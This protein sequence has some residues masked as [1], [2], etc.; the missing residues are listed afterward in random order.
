MLGSYPQTQ[1][2]PGVGGLQGS[3][4]SLISKSD[5]RYE[6][7]LYSINPDENTVALRN[8]KMLGTEGRK[9]GPQIPKGDQLYEFIIFRGSDIK[10]LT[11]FDANQRPSESSHP[12]DPA[13]LNAWKATPSRNNNNNWIPKPQNQSWGNNNNRGYQQNRNWDN[14]YNNNNNNRGGRQPQRYERKDDRHDNRNYDRRDNN[15]GYDRNNNYRQDDRRQGRDDR[16]QNQRGRVGNDGGR[17]RGYSGGSGGYNKPRRNNSNKHT[18]KNFLVS[19]D[20][21]K[22]G[23]EFTEDFN[24][25]ENNKKLDLDKVANEFKEKAQAAQSA[26]DNKVKA[27]FSITTSGYDKTKSFFDE[28]SCEALE[29]KIAGSEPKRLDRETREQQKQ[30][31]QETFG[32]ANLADAGGYGYGPRRGGFRGRRSGGGQR[33]YGGRY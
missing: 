2:Q 22:K 32:T 26:E 8:V 30:L 10:D 19:K 17:S 18:G 28:I 5:I 13:I 16:G 12:P 1:P 3:C 4:I 9:N 21:D 25:E 7:F 24:F 6:G 15:R 27:Q 20:A 33:N 11:V 14:Q 29:R 31:D 23:K